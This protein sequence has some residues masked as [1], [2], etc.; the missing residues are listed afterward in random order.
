MRTLR[1]FLIA[2][3]FVAACGQKTDSGAEAGATTTDSERL[4]VMVEE[5]FQENLEMNPIF[6]TFIGDNRYNDRLAI[7]IGPEHRAASLAMEQRY[8]ARLGEINP[9][10]LE[11]QDLLSYEIFKR[12][13]EEAIEAFEYPSHL[14]PVNQFF[15]FPNFMALL[16]SGANVQPFDTVEDYDNWLGRAA[17]IPVWMDQAVANMREGIEAGVVQPRIL[18]EK[19]LPQL[20][21]HIIDNPEDTIFYRPITNMPEDFSDEDR[22]RLTVAYMAAISE[23]IVPAYQRL[24]DFIRDEYIPKARETVGLK[25]LPDGDA[26]YAFLVRRTTTTDL[27][28]VEIHQIGL[29]E[30]VRIH[31]EMAGV[32]EQ[33]GFEGTLHEFFD[34]LNSDLQF[35]A[36]TREELIDGY[37][38][39]RD[40]VHAKAL[41][42]FY[43]LPKSDYEIRAVEPF[44]EKSASGGSYTA[45]SPDGSRPGIFYANTYDL[46]ARPKWAMESLFLHEAVPGHHFQNALHRE[47]EDLPSFRRFGGNT[48]YGEG[49]GL[50]SESL[51]KAL[52]VYTDPYQYF[53]ALNAE[54]WRAIRLV[55]DTGYHYL[56]W[57]RQD[58]LDY[59]YEN[60]ATKEARAVSE[61]ER[62]IAIPSQALAYK[63][64]QLKIL[65]LRARAEAALGNDFDVKAFHQEVLEDGELPMAILEAKID[66]WIGEQRDAA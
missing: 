8:L 43:A 15:S 49:W 16:G 44:R 7:S 9:E 53:G 5:Y 23:Q 48:A 24:H 19:T 66:R 38:A 10:H 3:L 18:M 22:D 56:G 25:D 29:D 27:T 1:I 35:Y 60:S 6:A 32:M 57:T 14:I 55:V 45:A 33:V 64:G 20:Q 59:M 31:G 17:D 51:G 52:G 4:N 41:K 2:L 61:A 11:G 46:S 21:A 63:I 30:V 50:Y 12:D 34:Y 13:L 65:E 54:L 58:V 42:L 47:L 36:K 40:D 37:Y 62:Y 26:W 28:P 39:L